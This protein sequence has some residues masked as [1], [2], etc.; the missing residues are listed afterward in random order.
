VKEL[1]R[2]TWR[3]RIVI[4]A[5]ITNGYLDSGIPYIQ[6]LKIFICTQINSDCFVTYVSDSLRLYLSYSVT[7]VESNCMFGSFAKQFDSMLMIRLS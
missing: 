3:G 7:S 6:L 1:K 5:V 4:V 2:G